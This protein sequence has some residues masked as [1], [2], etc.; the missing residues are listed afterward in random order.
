MGFNL[1]PATTVAAPLESVW[2][3]LGNPANYDE[4][5]DARTERIVPE[6]QTSPGQILY[7]KTPAFGRQWDVTL[8]IEQVKP[9]KHQIQMLIALPLGVVNHVTISCAT[10]DATSCRVQFG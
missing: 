4:W 7:A 6:G 10:I 5:W 3:L 8:K 9:E 1:C 2:E